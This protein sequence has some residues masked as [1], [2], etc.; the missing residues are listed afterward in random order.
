[1]IFGPVYRLR[2]GGEFKQIRLVLQG[3][4]HEIPVNNAHITLA[5]LKKKKKKVLKVMGDSPG[6]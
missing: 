1:M 5:A 6:S 4:C 2:S 3:L